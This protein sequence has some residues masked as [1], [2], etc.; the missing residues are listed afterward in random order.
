[1]NSSNSL[2]TFKIIMKTMNLCIMTN[3]PDKNNFILRHVKQ[4][5]VLS[6]KRHML[7]GWIYR[8]FLCQRCLRKMNRINGISQIH[9]DGV[10]NK[11]S[12]DHRHLIPSA[13]RILLPNLSPAKKHSLI[14]A[15]DLLI[16]IIGIH[17]KCHHHL[18]AILVLPQKLRFQIIK[19]K[20]QTVL[21]LHKSLF[22]CFFCMN[23]LSLTWTI[24]VNVRM[25]GI[26]KWLNIILIIASQYAY[27]FGDNF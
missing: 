9:W 17:Q 19:L 5:A 11:A 25:H 7:Y 12:P 13:L 21:F 15:N 22:Q 26:N 2:R 23:D 3:T 10:S 16:R 4:T 14:T 8:K 20:S 1:M 6:L 27:A 18:A 24:P